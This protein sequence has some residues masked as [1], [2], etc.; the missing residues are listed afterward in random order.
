MSNLTEA[1]ARWDDMTP[2]QCDAIATV[3]I[4]G[5]RNNGV[6]YWL[7][8]NEPI[9]LVSKWH[10]TTDRNDCADAVRALFERYKIGDH[11]T[12]VWHTFGEKLW[13]ICGVGFTATLVNG[14]GKAHIVGSID[15]GALI[16]LDPKDVC[17]AM[18]EALARGK[19]GHE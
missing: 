5:W 13:D 19:D 15:L 6:G 8:G 14:M 3:S 4:M 2:L 7:L 12:E 17:C 1:L 10:P 16:L 18:L 9:R 11:P